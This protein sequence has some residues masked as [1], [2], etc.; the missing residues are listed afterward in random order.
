MVTVGPRWY[1]IQLASELFLSVIAIA[2]LATGAA[3]R[4]SA[5]QQINSDIPAGC[6]A[7]EGRVLDD[8][9]RP[10]EGVKVYSMV[11]GHPPRSRLPSTT[12]DLK[13]LFYLGCAELGMNS[14]SVAKEDDYY[15]DTLLTPFNNINPMRIPAVNI[16]DQRLNRGV[17]IHLPPRGGRLA[18]RIVDAATQKPVEG[19]FLMVCRASHPDD[20]RRFDANQTSISGGFSLLLPAIPLRVKASAPGYED[21]NYKSNGKKGNT[22]VV[23]LTPG[24]TN[25]LVIALRAKR[26]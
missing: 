22:D 24:V 18:G 13:G 16:A 2:L 7:I 4:V 12:T 6:G 1:Q 10:V 8:R 26:D 21:W 14:I 3:A 25:T 11:R 9:N 15:L 19:A 17:V 23:Q 5:S 20:C